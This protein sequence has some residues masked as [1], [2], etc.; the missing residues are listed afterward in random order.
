MPGEDEQTTGYGSMHTEQKF[1][2]HEFGSPYSQE[3]HLYLKATRPYFILTHDGSPLKHG[4]SSNL[5][6]MT[7]QKG[8]FLGFIHHVVSI[9]FTI[10]LA[11]EVSFQNSKVCAVSTALYT[12]V[13]L[14]N[15]SQVFTL[16]IPANGL[17]AP[18]TLAASMVS[19]L[20][21]SLS[22]ELQTIATEL[23]PA[24]KE[25]NIQ[26]PIARTNIKPT[27]DASTILHLQSLTMLA[28]QVKISPLHIAAFILHL[29]LKR[30]LSLSQRQICQIGSNG[31]LG[32]VFAKDDAFMKSLGMCQLKL[33]GNSG[34]SHGLI[35]AIPSIGSLTGFGFADHIDGRLFKYALAN[36]ASIQ[37]MTF[38]PD[39]LAYYASL[40]E[41]CK[42]S[43]GLDISHLDLKH[44]LG[45]AAK[46]R[47]QVPHKKAPG[48]LKVLPFSNPVFNKHLSCIR[49]AVDAQL[50]AQ[51]PTL[52]PLERALYETHWHSTRRLDGMQTRGDKL[53]RISRKPK[54]WQ[55]K[56]N[57]IAR[58]KMLRYAKNLAGGDINPELIIVKT[59][60]GR[61]AVSAAKKMESQTPKTR[62]VKAAHSQAS[63]TEQIKAANEQ[64]IS[65]KNQTKAVASWKSFYQEICV[66]CETKRC[67]IVAL[68]GFIT[69]CKEETITIEARLFKCCLLFEVWKGEYCVSEENK[70]R[71]YNLVALIFNEAKLI[72]ASPKLTVSIKDA[73][74]SIFTL[75]GF[76]PLPSP[77]SFP[78]LGKATFILPPPLPSKSLVDTGA[79]KDLRLHDFQLQYCG[80]YMERNLDPADDP[81]VKF[82]PDAWQIKVLDALDE[83]KSVFVVAPTS[84]GKTFIAYYAMEKVRE[85]PFSPHFKLSDAYPKILRADNDGVLVYVAPTKALVSP[86]TPL[87]CHTSIDKFDR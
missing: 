75:L 69:K 85:M 71:G 76:T 14:H 79:G 7:L 31:S 73:L 12:H 9:N 70:S 51:M 74:D 47:G 60:S 22:K 41:I 45:S 58:T 28:K 21:E 64:R 37:N 43:S 61:I 59:V 52:S 13:H 39:S 80:P 30:F 17:T 42:G 87:M 27:L 38:T 34:D 29:V 62:I 72:L 32:P 24:F 26:D 20:H 77:K 50:S 68:T 16:I 78:S 33:L 40:I 82:R 44:H 18:S 10:G 66:P 11:Q 81:R 15:N 65:M 53:V 25:G 8:I 86:L 4:N 46:Y 3:F 83:D 67:A 57:Q 49:L 63:K 19:Q 2:V 48:S 55:L 6:R 54:W 56:G 84:A 35:S 5:S 1:Q 23:E 36:T